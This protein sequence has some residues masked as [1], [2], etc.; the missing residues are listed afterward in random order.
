MIFH[1]LQYYQ[2]SSIEEAVSVFFNLKE[3]GKKPMYYA[4]GTEIVS[5][6]RK[7]LLRPN[8]LI[9]IKHIKECLLMEMDGNTLFYGS[10][11]PLNFVAQSIQF[12]LLADVSKTIADHTI[13]NRLTLGGNICGRLPY[14]EAVLPFLLVP[15]TAVV[16]SKEGLRREPLTSSFNK[17]LKL[18]EGEFLVQLI[19]DRTYASLPYSRIRNQRS[20][21]VDYPLLHVA[22]LYLEGETRIATSGLCSFPFRAHAVESA[23]NDSSSFILQISDKMDKLL[24]APVKQDHLASSDY[25]KALFGL[26]LSDIIAHKGG[27]I[28]V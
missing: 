24:P 25:R 20:G 5:M 21:K 1:D 12:P 10:A 16:A 23:L 7:G 9:D 27:K 6:A 4:G 28:Y 17:R 14:K 26:A 2:P 13:R 11:V 15:T 8:A 3:Q 22:A 19:V 18:T